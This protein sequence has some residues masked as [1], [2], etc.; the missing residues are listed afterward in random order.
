M[1]EKDLDIKV[2]LNH[3][4]VMTNLNNAVSHVLK[5]E[6]IKSVKDMWGD[7]TFQH[8]MKKK[9]RAIMVVE[10]EKVIMEIL[11]DYD[12]I[13]E[14]VEQQVFNSMSARVAKITKR[15]EDAQ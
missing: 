8:D 15:L 10:G 2:T 11:S 13:K 1:S 14:R 12:R 3:E 5:A 7:Y 4:E 9:L 6:M